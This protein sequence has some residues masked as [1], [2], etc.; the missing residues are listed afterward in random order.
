MVDDQSARGT[1]AHNASQDCWEAED[2]FDFD[3]EDEDEDEEE[4]DDNEDEE[5][6]DAEEIDIYR[7]HTIYKEPITFAFT[8]RLC[9][10]FA[11]SFCNHDVY[12]TLTLPNLNPNP[13]EHNCDD[14]KVVKA[15]KLLNDADINDVLGSCKVYLDSRSG[16]RLKRKVI[17]I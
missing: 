14:E 5:D 13:K 17:R 3:D 7:F 6:D 1:L 12:Q 11:N 10:F 16:E 8:N 4:G 9:M 15:L 2:E